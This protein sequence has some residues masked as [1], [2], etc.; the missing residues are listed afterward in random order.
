MISEERDKKDFQTRKEESC[1]VKQNYAGNRSMFYE[2]EKS[3]G[4]RGTGADPLDLCKQF[5]S[6]ADAVFRVGDFCHFQCSLCL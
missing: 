4:Q 6:R 2:R 5:C 3:T 1:P